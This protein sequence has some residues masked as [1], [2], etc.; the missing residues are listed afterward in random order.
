MIEL[1]GY[2]ISP[3]AITFLLSFIVSYIVIFILLKNRGIPKGVIGLS[4][5]L[6]TIMCIYGAMMY[7]VIISGFRK[8]ILQS[9]FSSLGGVSG[10]LISI[11]IMTCIYQERKNAFWEVYLAVLPLFYAISKIGCAITGCCHGISYNG[12][13]AITYNNK[14]IQTGKVFP[15]QALES[16]VFFFIF[17]I[18]ISV[19]FKFRDY[20]RSVTLILCSLFKGSLDWFRNE[21]IGVII[22]PNQIVCLMF[23]IIGLFLLFKEYKNRAN[24]C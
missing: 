11:W 24:N 20:N 16:I 3:Y 21:H 7:G 10:L 4:F 12:F 13:L 15:I 22:S 14:F 6:G 8:G 2:E 17:I 23:L 1:L 18:S 9:G 5:M 19:Y